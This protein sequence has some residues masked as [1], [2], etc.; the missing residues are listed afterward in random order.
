MARLYEYQSK[1]L[2]K[3]EGIRIPE[4]DVASSPEEACKIAQVIGK[5]VVLKIQVWSTGRAQ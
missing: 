5:P 2:L 3:E 1:F 4:G